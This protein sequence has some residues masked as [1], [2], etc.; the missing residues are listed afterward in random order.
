MSDGRDTP[1]PTGLRNRVSFF[2]RV[3]RGSSRSSSQDVESTADVEEIE[4]RIEQRKR[5]PES[6]KID[7][8]LKQT[9]DSESPG[10]S[11]VTFPNVKLRHVEPVEETERVVRQV[12]EG[13]LTS[14]VRYVKFER[15]SLKRTVETRSEDRPDSPQHEWYTEYKNQALHTA[16][17]KDYLRSKSEY[18]SHIAQIR[19][20]IANMSVFKKGYKVQSV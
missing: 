17:R 8:K 3:W 15:V 19:G 12:E 10:K 13:D 5:R 20:E 1:P 4:R 14:G 16:P 9:R 2:E 6:P 7:V 11:D 18:D